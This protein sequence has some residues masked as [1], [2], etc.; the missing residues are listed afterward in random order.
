[1]EREYD[2]VGCF[3]GRREGERYLAVGVDV[4]AV[5]GEVA[6][7]V[8]A[9]ARLGVVALGYY[10][11]ILHQPLSFDGDSRLAAAGPNYAVWNLGEFE[12]RRPS[13]E[14]AA[15]MGGILE[16]QVALCGVGTVGKGEEE[17]ALAML[18]AVKLVAMEVEYLQFERSPRMVEVANTNRAGAVAMIEGAVGGGLLGRDFA[19]YGRLYQNGIGAE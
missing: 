8:S 13:E 2:T 1:M 19:L 17:V 9:L 5:V 6:V 18:V 16:Q 10:H 12:V 14:E 11:H 15:R 3:L 7:Q 4:E